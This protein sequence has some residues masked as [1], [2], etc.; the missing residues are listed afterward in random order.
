VSAIQRVI[1]DRASGAKFAGADISVYVSQIK[2]FYKVYPE[3]DPLPSETS[4][5]AWDKSLDAAA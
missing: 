2:T 5:N 4:C 1:G 3:A